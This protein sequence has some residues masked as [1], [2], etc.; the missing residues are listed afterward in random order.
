MSQA[1]DR[2]R[3]HSRFGKLLGQ[4]YPWSNTNEISNATTKMD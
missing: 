1:V 3:K 4:F 2:V